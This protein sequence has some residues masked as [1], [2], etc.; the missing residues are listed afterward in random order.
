MALQHNTMVSAQSYTAARQHSVVLDRSERACI[1]VSGADRAS[2]LQGL[3][4]N[5]IAALKG[6]QGCY[7]A[8]L[9]PQGRMI[10][11]LFVYELG[12]AMLLT[13]PRQEKDL[14][15]K[16]LDQF[17]FN[18][19]VQLG[20]V[21]ETFSAVAVVGPE[22]ARIVSTLVTG[23]ADDLTAWPPHANHR[24]EFEGRSAILTRVVDTG[25]PGYDI[26]VE[27]DQIDHLRLALAAAGT[28]DADLETAEALRIEGGVPK[29]NRDMDRET[30]PLEAGIE[31]LAIS[32]SKGC[33]VGQEVI[34]RVL[35]RGHGRVARKL[36][37][38]VLDGESPP[39]AGTAV[40]AGAREI[41]D[42]RSSVMSP[43][44]TCPIALAYL[45]RDFLTP[46]TR[47]SVAGHNA[48][49]TE[50]P[51]VKSPRA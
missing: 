46:G 12:D 13:V 47:V 26:Y 14:V 21:T 20:D 18:E 42:V 7:S 49:V 51:F 50:L 43:A 48:T 17:V 44:L 41:G 40:A 15:L 28:V 31:S 24:V 45:H 4:T 10:A 35:H 11:D 36:V 30:I 29:F 22:S 34:I 1:A 38:L 19:D 8:Y 16:K 33:Y 3:L 27:R 2:Y 23:T 6:G 25:E 37:G 39:P 9:T 32:F 5:D